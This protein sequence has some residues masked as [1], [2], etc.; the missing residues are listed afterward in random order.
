[1][2][3]DRFLQ[4][5]PF[6]IQEAIFPKSEQAHL[7]VPGHLLSSYAPGHKTH[8][9]CPTMYIIYGVGLGGEGGAHI[10]IIILH[11]GQGGHI[12]TTILYVGQ[13]W[14]EGG[15]HMSIIIWYVGQGGRVGPIFQ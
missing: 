4:L 1:M 9:I 10:S 8:S 14:G 3:G 11:V 13:R 15:A 7:S 5:L 12:S 2:F 6:Q